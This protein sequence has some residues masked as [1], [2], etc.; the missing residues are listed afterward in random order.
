MTEVGPELRALIVRAR[1]D[2]GRW[3][4]GTKG[5]SQQA[6]ADL[7]TQSTG[8]PLSQV[9]LRQIETGYTGTARADTLGNILITLRIDPV[10]VRK[11]GYSDVADA[12]EASIM[13]TDNEVPDHL[14]MSAEEHLRDT[15][16][17]DGRQ[18][19]L[20]VDALREIRRQEPL[21]KDIWRRRR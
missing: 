18:K 10:L 16:G 4:G 7:V 3:N 19:E 21:G 14:L 20:L 11:I 12:M 15:P 8:V 6:L 2:P 5:L 13:L 1:K 17:L 9:W